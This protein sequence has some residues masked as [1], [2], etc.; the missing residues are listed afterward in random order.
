M[1]KFRWFLKKSGIDYNQHQ[2]DGVQW[3]LHNE[4]R[5]D[6][7]YRGGLIADEMGLGKTITMIGVLIAN[8]M[9][10]TLIVLPNVLIQQW[11]REI[12]RT[13]GHKSVRQVPRVP[14]P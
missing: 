2:F 6:I 11:A 13:T 12:F 1:D 14:H 10:R 7:K 3:A 5:P 8:F 9:P 4:T